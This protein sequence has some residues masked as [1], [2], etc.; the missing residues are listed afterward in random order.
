[1]I[2]FLST[3]WVG[4]AVVFATETLRELAVVVR[5]ARVALDSSVTFSRTSTRHFS[6][7]RSD[8]HFPNA[9]RGLN[10]SR[11][12][13]TSEQAPE[14]ANGQ[15]WQK[16]QPRDK[17]DDRPDAQHSDFDNPPQEFLHEDGKR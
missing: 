10:H 13:P 4:L 8:Q 17:D 2:P 7:N 16:A 3:T 11:C 1:M 5:F 12:R 15:P 6:G 14:N 9:R